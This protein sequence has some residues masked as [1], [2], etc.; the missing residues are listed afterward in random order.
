VFA[1]LYLGENP[2]MKGSKDNHQDDRHEYRD[3]KPDHDPVKQH[4]DYN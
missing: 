3:E 1:I 4:A 2:A